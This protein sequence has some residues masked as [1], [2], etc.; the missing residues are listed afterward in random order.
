LHLRARIKGV[1][2]TEGVLLP[3][4]VSVKPSHDRNRIAAQPFPTIADPR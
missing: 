3:S 2:P 4:V 1:E